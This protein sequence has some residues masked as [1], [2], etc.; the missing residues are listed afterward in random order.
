[1]IGA[2]RRRRRT[3]G[4]GRH[5]SPTECSPTAPTEVYASQHREMRL[6]ARQSTLVIALT[7]S[8]ADASAWRALSVVTAEL[9]SR[10]APHRAHLGRGREHDSTTTLRVCRFVLASLTFSLALWSSAHMPRRAALL[11]SVGGSKTRDQCNRQCEACEKRRR[12]F[13]S[14]KIKLIPACRHELNGTLGITDVHA[15]SAASVDRG[16]KHLLRSPA[17]PMNPV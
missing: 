14:S 13:S 1:M 4:R 11:S 8:A 5:L 10:S 12:R 9:A 6:C 3:D 16:A 15:S 17:D 7:S 2:R